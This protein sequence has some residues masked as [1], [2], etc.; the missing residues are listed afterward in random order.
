M[1]I[2]NK[3]GFFNDRGIAV[4]E[5]K[6]DYASPFDEDGTALVESDSATYYIYKD[7]TFAGEATN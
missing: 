7:G 2:N 5:A 6:Y 1:R 4:I 3:I